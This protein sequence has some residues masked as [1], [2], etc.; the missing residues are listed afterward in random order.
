MPCSTASKNPTCCSSTRFARWRRARAQR[1]ELRALEHEHGA[2]GERQRKMQA[3]LAELG[4]QLDMCF[5]NRNEELARKVVK[6]GSRPSASSGTSASGARRV[7]QDARSTPRRVDEQREQLD[8]MRQKAELLTTRQ[9]ATIG[10]R[11]SSPSARPRSKSRSCASDRRGS[12]HERA[13]S[14]TFARHGD[15]RRVH[16]E[17][18]GAALLAALV[19]VAW[20]RAALRAVIALLGLAYMLYL[21]GKSGERVGRITTIVCWV[22]IASV[23]WFSGCR[24]SHTCWCTSGSCGWCALSTTTRAC[25]RRS[26][27]W[28]ERA[29]RGVRRLGRAALGH[30]LARFLVFLPRSSV[31][32]A[33]PRYAVE[34]AGG[35]RPGRSGV[36]TRASRRGSGRAPFV[37]ASANRNLQLESEL[38]MKTNILVT[39]IVLATVGTVLIYPTIRGN[40]TGTPQSSKVIA[41]IGTKRVEV[42]FVLDTTGSMGGLIE[43]AKEKI[44][45]I[46]SRSPAQ[47]APEI[48]IGLV[49]YRDR[50]DAYVTQVVD[51]TAT[52]TRCTR[53]CMDF[54]ADGGG[55]G[56]ESVNQALERRGH[57]MSWSQDRSTLQ[58]HLPGRRRAAAHGLPGRREVPGDRRGRGRSKGIIINTIQCGSMSG[59]RGA[60]AAHR[61]AGPRPLLHG[62]AGRQRRR[63]GDA[64]RRADRDA[65][66]P[67]STTRACT[68]AP[69]SRSAD[70]GQGRRDRRVSTRKRRSPRTRGAARS[71]S[72]S[73]REQSARRERARRGRR[74]R[75]RRHRGGPGGAL[76]AAVAALPVEEQRALLGRRRTEARGAAAADREARRGTRRVHRRKDRGR[77]RR[78]RTRSTSRSTK[79][80]ESRPRRSAWTT[81][82]GR[83]SDRSPTRGAAATAP[84]RD[85][86]RRTYQSVR[87][88]ACFSA[89]S[90]VVTELIRW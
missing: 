10:A 82:T 45:S 86:S 37:L 54:T 49:A 48:S 22:A 38:N 57:K 18:C 28:G 16:L 44:W 90:S 12:R 63:D 53:S 23:T 32:R 70:G 35:A 11:R 80:S 79:P 9:P 17:R 36:R 78:R 62:G 13:A 21:I 77:R 61:G 85:P 24:S 6:R 42:V 39:G 14:Q 31:L 5:A 55:D 50:G 71:T 84:R 75:P 67:S 64:V 29:R 3:V 58:G 72:A 88:S 26:R 87:R 89:I 40:A 60:V 46:A 73:R 65:R 41:P 81:R 2:L 27:T 25:C 69:T 74:E 66:R 1:A 83:A 33:H 7:D 51:L 19:A 56:P 34:P 15:R 4:E 30:R 52:S 47:P 43:A 59:D 20:R 8:V 68:T 76:P